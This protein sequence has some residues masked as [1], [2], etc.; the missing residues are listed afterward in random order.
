MSFAPWV[1]QHNDRTIVFSCFSARSYAMLVYVNETDPVQPK[2][3]PKPLAESCVLDILRLFQC[4]IR[5]LQECIFGIET[6]RG[7]VERSHACYISTNPGNMSI[8]T[9]KKLLVQRP[10]NRRGREIPSSL[11]VQVVYNMVELVLEGSYD[12]FIPFSSFA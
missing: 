10:T 2:S 6:L 11:L 8:E 4:A 12:H 1:I 9:R 7:P 3:P 5:G